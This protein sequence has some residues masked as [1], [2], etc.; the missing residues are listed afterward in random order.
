MSDVEDPTPLSPSH[1]LYGRNIKTLPYPNEK[2]TDAS[3]EVNN[4]S[5]EEF[6]DQHS[7]KH[8]IIEHFWK[9]RRH[10]YLT[11]LREFHCASG[12][13]MQNIKIWEVV[14]IHDDVPRT[15]WK[16]AVLEELKQGRDGYTS[17]LL[18]LERLLDWPTDPSW[19]YIRWKS[20]D[21]MRPQTSRIEISQDR[22]QTK[23]KE[24]DYDKVIILI[25]LNCHMTYIFL[26]VNKSD[27]AQLDKANCR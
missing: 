19:S 9:R 12:K 13:T 10:K 15:Q 16:L 25:L 6:N 27:L 23:Y 20:T 4:E 24:L 26:L 18:N 17:D 22:G 14:Q 5:P 8:E 21:V 2:T 11:S 1:P 3:D 7:R